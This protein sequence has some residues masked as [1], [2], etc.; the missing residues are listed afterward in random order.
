M[1]RR[2]LVATVCIPAIFYS[3]SSFE[4]NVTVSQQI[5]EKSIEENQPQP[6]LED[7]PVL[8]EKPA[9]KKPV[10]ITE[11]QWSEPEVSNNQVPLISVLPEVVFRKIAVDDEIFE[12]SDI[13]KVPDVEAELPENISIDRIEEEDVEADEPID[14]PAVEKKPSF[15]ELIFSPGAEQAVDKAETLSKSVKKETEPEVVR[16]E[17]VVIK[18]KEEESQSSVEKQEPVPEMH[19]A[20][21]VV[22]ELFITSVDGEG[23][24]YERCKTADG[25]ETDNLKYSGREYLDGVTV[26]TFFPYQTGTYIIQLRKPDYSNG[27]TVRAVINLEV[28]ANPANG[29]VTEPTAEENI[30]EIVSEEPVLVV[31]EKQEILNAAE[32]EIAAEKLRKAGG[33]REAAELIL[34]TMDIIEWT[35]LDSVYFMLAGLYENCP[36]IRDER[37]AAGYYRKIVDYYP[38]SV[39]WMDAKE[40]IAYLERNF[41]YIR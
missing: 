21:V 29:S 10:L 5:D 17:T 7:K 11:L 8:K 32:L 34:D 19:E 9:E 1:F 25:N 33:C 30:S 23:W 6:L 27:T 22:R 38:V 18:K 15:L 4:K 36:G 37:A 16:E 24:L 35:E 13:E 41:L 12:Q 26:F 14:I 39:Y 40:R 3:C 31:G 20:E 28:K 2:L